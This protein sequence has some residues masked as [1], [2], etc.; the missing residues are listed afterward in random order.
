MANL[1]LSSSAFQEGEKIP[2]QYTCDGQNVSPPLSWSGTPEGT[3][4][5]ALIVDDPDAPS[6]TYTHWVVYDLS[7]GTSELPEGALQSGG[8]GQ[9]V[10]GKN[11]AGKTAYSGPCPP[12]GNPH[13]YFFKLYALDQVLGLKAGST[14]SDLER[15]MQGH[16]LAQGQLMGKYGR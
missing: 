10:Q 14:K 15:A 3:Q 6:G 2:T 1:Q 12:R 4:S 5:L 7:P 8:T 11:S 13:R 16:M 9:A